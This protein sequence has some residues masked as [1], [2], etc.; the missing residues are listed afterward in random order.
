VSRQGALK[1]TSNWHHAHKFR[2][3]DERWDA[4]DH[5]R[6]AHGLTAFPLFAGVK[7]EVNGMSLWVEEI[8]PVTVVQN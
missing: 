4:I 8:K 7:V 6:E 1:L 5:I 3:G 2:T